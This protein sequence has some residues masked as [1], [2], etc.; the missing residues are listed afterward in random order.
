[1]NIFDI[2]IEN[3]TYD[4]ML[5]RI[6]D[7][8]EEKNKLSFTYVNT[9]VAV[10][11][12]QNDSLKKDLNKISSLYIDGIGMYWA[13]RALNTSVSIK[14]RINATDLNYRILDLALESNYKVFFFGG[15]AEAHEKLHA[16]LS[17]THPHIKITG[18]IKRS[19]YNNQ[20]V[21]NLIN[22]SNPDILFV[23]LGTPEQEKWISANF[24][25]INVPIVVGVG[26]WIEFATG[27]YPR[28]PMIMRKL[29]FEWL[30][31][32][33]LEP[34]RLWKRYLIGIPVFIY[35]LTKEYFNKRDNSNEKCV[36]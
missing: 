15:G 16:K 35:F 26:S 32:L 10:S 18:A 28:A 36:N 6:R 8:I 21:L 33:I 11:A 23:G 31:R 7:S 30:F 4:D 17:Q 22:S 29:G 3:Y 2:E 19:D 34:G 20:E 24:E 12:S 5:N 13:L 9:F 14:E 1:M 27:V 25:K